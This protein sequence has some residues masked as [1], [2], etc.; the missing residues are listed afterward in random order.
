MAAVR[1]HAKS[2]QVHGECF[3]PAAFE[4]Y[5]GERAKQNDGWSGK[6]DGTEQ[7]FNKDSIK[8]FIS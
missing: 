4:T 3:V 2:E 8:P 7:G 1:Y 5:E 6:L